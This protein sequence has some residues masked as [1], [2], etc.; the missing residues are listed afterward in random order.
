MWFVN[1]IFWLQAFIAPVLLGGL[2]G[3][4]I[5]SVKWIIILLVV[6]AVAGIIIAEYIRRK[7]G[8][9]N[10]FG[11]TYGQ[12]EMDEKLKEKKIK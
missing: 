8:L 11:R 7:I 4:I 12:N 6:G 3:I 2:I 1:I 9:S 5:G 10:F